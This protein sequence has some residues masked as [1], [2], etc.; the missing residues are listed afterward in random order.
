[1]T[2]WAERRLDFIAA[3]V[4]S[5]LIVVIIQPSALKMIAI[6]DSLCL[7]KLGKCQSFKTLEETCKVN[8][9]RCSH[10]LEILEIMSQSVF[11]DKCNHHEVELMK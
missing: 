6:I 1:M 7:R 4:V 8:C 10:T 2:S 9:E 11:K 5:T 3:N